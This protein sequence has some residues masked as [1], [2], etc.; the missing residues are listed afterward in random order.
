MPRPWILRHIYCLA[1]ALLLTAACRGPGREVLHYDDP[2]TSGHLQTA[3]GETLTGEEATCA[4]EHRFSVRLPDGVEVTAP[5]TLGPGAELT[6]QGCV[7][8]HE[9][10]NLPLDGDTLTIAVRDGSPAQP[11]L[12]IPLAPRP[13][14]FERRLS[15]AGLGARVTVHLTAHLPS[16]RRLL[17]RDLSASRRSRVEMPKAPP[18][19]VLLISVDTLRRD[20]L[21]TYGGPWPTPALDRFAARAQTWLSHVAAASWTKPS[22]ASLFSGQS[23]A[24]VVVETPDAPIPATLPLLAERFQAAGFRTGALVFDC[25][26]LNPPFGFS[27]GFETYRSVHWTLPQARRAL[28]NWIADHQAEP[29]FFFLHT[30]EPH[31][32]FRALPYEGPGVTRRTVLS[33]FGV[34]DYGCR[35]EQ[36]AS[37]VLAAINDGRITPLPNEGEILRFLYGEGVR[38]MDAELGALFADLDAMGLFDPMMIIVTSDHGE[39]FLEHGRVLHG[40]SFEEVMRVPLIVKW[41][42]GRFAGERREELTSTLDLA[43]TL[44]AAHGMADGALPGRDLARLEGEQPVFAWD[45]GQMVYSGPW[46]A[47]FGDREGTALY[48]L[49][50]DPGETTNLAASRPEVLARLERLAAARAGADQ[51]IATRLARVTPSGVLPTLAPE[52]IRRLQAL[53]YL[54]GTPGGVPPRE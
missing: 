19:Q 34:A 46:K 25:L 26:W 30:F 29:F 10:P 47:V 45:P 15:L 17:L 3:A 20:G 43:P 4:L 39:S 51:V 48:H 49:G 22:H 32:D 31:S 52:D 24:V 27:R 42:G 14:N 13:G 8:H 12:T 16:G 35:Q 37:G 54:G 41:P 28:T 11:A 5:L 50:D 40:H 21:S 1:P 6:V 38:H 18:P 53:G 7:G 9:Q 23:P 2:V 44:L 36:C 33:R